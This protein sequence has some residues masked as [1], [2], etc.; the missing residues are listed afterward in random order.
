MYKEE[1]VTE[2][3]INIF[4]WFWSTEST[5]KL[6]L[7]TSAEY[8]IATTAKQ[9]IKKNEKFNHEARISSLYHLNLAMLPESCFIALTLH[10]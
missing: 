2:D 9:K 8:K 4:V 10:F 6:I 7:L 5:E 3:L 1:K